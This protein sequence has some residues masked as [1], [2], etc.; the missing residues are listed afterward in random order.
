MHNNFYYCTIDKRTI[1]V[2]LQIVGV[3]VLV[4]SYYHV[5]INDI[6]YNIIYIIY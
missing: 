1:V 4:T 6:I 2:Y 5:P 3:W